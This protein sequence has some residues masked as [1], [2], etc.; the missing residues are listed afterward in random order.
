MNLNATCLCR[1]M[2]N[3]RQPSAFAIVF[4]LLPIL[5]SPPASNGECSGDYVYSATLVR[6]ALSG[7]VAHGGRGHFVWTLGE[8]RHKLR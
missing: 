5:S 2:V 6:S 3:F 1:K 8:G 7:D 4:L